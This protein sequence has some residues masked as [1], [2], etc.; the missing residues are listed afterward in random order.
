[1]SLLWSLR[2]IIDIEFR[3]GGEEG[4]TLREESPAPVPGGTGGVPRW[5]RPETSRRM[6]CRLCGWAA[7]NTAFCHECHA[8]TMERVRG[9]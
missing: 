6:R 1:M 7:S 5:M 4:K 8:E 3:A 9:G 2:K